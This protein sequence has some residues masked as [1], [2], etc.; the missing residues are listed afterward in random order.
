MLLVGIALASLGG[1]LGGAGVVIALL[2]AVQ[3]LLLVPFALIAAENGTIIFCPIKSWK[4]WILVP[5]WQ[6]I[7]LI[8]YL[9]SRLPSLIASLFRKETYMPFASLFRKETYMSFVRGP[10]LSAVNVVRGLAIL[11]GA[12]AVFILL[13]VAFEFVMSNPFLKIMLHIIEIMLY[14]IGGLF[15]LLYVIYILSVIRSSNK[16]IHQIFV[17]AIHQ[18]FVEPR[19][20]R[21]HWEAFIK[22]APGEV[23]CRE[24]WEKIE[25]YNLYT[26]A[27]EEKVIRS[28]REKRLLAATEETENFINF[29]EEETEAK[30]EQKKYES[31]LNSGITWLDRQSAD[32]KQFLENT[33]DYVLHELRLL[34]ED[35]HSRR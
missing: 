13:G 14:I 11:A 26:L 22:D 24:W 1:L 25:K 2:I 15:L 6:V 18:I 33:N 7:W 32:Y 4:P 3:T 29:L 12:L 30:L 10:L 17:E 5:A 16:S 20:H 31:S 23:T 21:K 34:L 28:T 35:V 8:F 9:L 27:S 19:Q